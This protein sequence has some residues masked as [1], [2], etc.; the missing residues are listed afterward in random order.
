MS[1]NAQLELI[2]APPPEPLTGEPALLL[3]LLVAEHRWMTRREIAACLGWSE[4]R[5]RDA[6][7]ASRGEIL[8]GPGSPGY[9][10]TRGATHEDMRA[11]WCLLSQAQAMKERGQQVAVVWERGQS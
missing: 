6:A 5:I 3:A 2:P 1:M 9:R 11:C 10:A 8:S 4:R 7:S